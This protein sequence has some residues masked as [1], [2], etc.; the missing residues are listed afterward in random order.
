MIDGLPIDDFI[1]DCRLEHRIGN[2]QCNQSS[3]KSAIINP[4]RQS[5]IVNEIGNYQSKSAIINRQ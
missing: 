4:N 1:C 5:S 2:R 3:M